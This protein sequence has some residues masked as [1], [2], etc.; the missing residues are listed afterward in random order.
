MA[1]A[2]LD[3]TAWLAEVAAAGSI[4][5]LIVGGGIN[6]C[7]TFR[8]LALQGVRCLL[9]D[10]E[11]FGAGASS[12]S[13]RMAHGGLRYLENGEFRLVAEATRERN[14]LLRNAPHAIAPLQVTIPSFS[15]LGGLAQSAAK[16]FGIE[17]KIPSRGMLMLKLGMALYDLL[18]RRQAVM[19][20]HRMTYAG[21]VR[22]LLPDLH[23]AVRGVASY[24]DAVIS[25]AERIAFELVADGLAANPACRA[26]NHCA[27][28]RGEGECDC[29]PDIAPLKGSN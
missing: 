28:L 29:E 11:D 24:Y 3:R 15:I 1:V 13:T 12:A 25:H 18:G 22:A 4:D 19:A 16:L 14:R 5:V 2:G 27:L 26:L 7:A 21:G 6:G 23:P 20:R 17:R 8:E 10:R 9:I